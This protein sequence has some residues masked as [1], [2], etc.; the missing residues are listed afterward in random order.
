MLSGGKPKRKSPK[1]K[2]IKRK[3]PKLQPST[4]DIGTK[5]K[6]SDGKMYQV[7]STKSGMGRAWKK[8][9]VK[10]PCKRR[11]FGPHFL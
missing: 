8:C 11:S 3:S 5:R 4:F 10:S 2:S 7:V 6:G 9:N 1:R